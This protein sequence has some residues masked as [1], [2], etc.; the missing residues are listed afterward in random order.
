MLVLSLTLA[1]LGGVGEGIFHALPDMTWNF[2]G[3][4]ARP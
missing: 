2:D 3:I 4:S 1:D